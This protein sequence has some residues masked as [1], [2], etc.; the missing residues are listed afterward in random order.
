MLC[1]VAVSV[2]VQPSF[3]DMLFS[4]NKIDYKIGNIL[5]HNRH[6]V[7]QFLF[8]ELS[9]PRSSCIAASYKKG[10]EDDNKVKQKIVMYRESG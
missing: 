9:N 10:E 4:V 7:G 6:P 2:S 8:V 5:V 1:R 3:K